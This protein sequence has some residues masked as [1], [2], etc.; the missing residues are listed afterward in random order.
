M[1]IVFDDRTASTTISP[2][3]FKQARA[4]YLALSPGELAA[5]RV[6]PPPKKKKSTGGATGQ[7]AAAATAP[8][9]SPE[10]TALATAP[11]VVAAARSAA[12]GEAAAAAP[13]LSAVIEADVAAVTT[14]SNLSGKATSR[15]KN[16]KKSTVAAAS[17]SAATVSSQPVITEATE[18]AGLVAFAVSSPSSSPVLTEAAQ[19]SSSLL[20]IEQIQP[21]LNNSNLPNLSSGS[22]FLCCAIADCTEYCDSTSAQL[23]VECPK[24]KRQTYLY[25]ALHQLHSSHINQSSSRRANT[26]IIIPSTNIAVLVATTSSSSSSSSSSAVLTSTTVVRESRKRKPTPELFELCKCGCGNTYDSSTMTFC[27]GR[28]GTGCCNLVRF[29][30]VPS[31]W[32][33]IYCK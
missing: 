16:R 29:T 3:V 4:A 7:A 28:G 20:S 31:T 15:K 33:C 27:K 19:S 25:C 9:L 22:K 18:A 30:C 14:E 21:V 32:L 13:P 6:E 11:A 12:A 26:P 2:T 5:D 23:C 10:A 17:I 8:A 24:N 1:Q